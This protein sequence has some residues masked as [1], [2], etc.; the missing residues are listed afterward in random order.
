VYIN[1]FEINNS[2][3]NFKLYMAKVL[4]TIG[5]REFVHLPELGLENIEAKIDT[6]AYRSALHCHHIAIEVEDNKKYLSFVVLDH[7]HHA[8]TGYKLRHE[9]FTKKKI[10]NS[11][12]DMEE[13]YIIKTKIKLGTKIVNTTIS[14][15]DRADMKYPILLGRKFLKGKFIVDVSKHNVSSQ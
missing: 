2:F 1:K 13:R 14:L 9:H 7:Q 8:Y 5:R 11:S 6:G 15:T 12:G 10:K 3:S 4:R